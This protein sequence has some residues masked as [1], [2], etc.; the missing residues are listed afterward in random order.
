MHINPVSKYAKCSIANG[1]NTI[2]NAPRNIFNFCILF[3]FFRINDFIYYIYTDVELAIRAI[4]LL[5]ISNI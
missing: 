3:F 5:I 1:L 4:K 2:K